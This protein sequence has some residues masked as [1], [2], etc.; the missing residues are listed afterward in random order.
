[1][2]SAPEVISTGDNS[3]TVFG[4]GLDTSVWALPRN[5]GVWGTSWISLGGL[6]ELA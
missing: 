1:L 3:I 2:N 4:V 6:F 5:V